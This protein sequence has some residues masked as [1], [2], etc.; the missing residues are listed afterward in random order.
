MYI[1][2]Q[3]ERQTGNEKQICWSDQ[4]LAEGV[5]RTEAV[6]PEI[7]QKFSVFFIQKQN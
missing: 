5:F 6:L 7:L 1:V 3:Y 4:H 2:Q